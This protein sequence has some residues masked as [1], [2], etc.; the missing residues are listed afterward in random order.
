MRIGMVCEAPADHRTAT[1]LA[2]RVLGHS[3]ETTCINPTI[4]MDQAFTRW[5]N[6]DRHQHDWPRRRVHGFQ[7]NSAP[8]HGQ[9]LAARKAIMLFAGKVDALIL[10][11]DG[12]DETNARRTAME[13]ARTDPRTPSP[14]RI[15]VAVPSPERE[16]WHIVGFDPKDD[17][18]R[19]KL[20][21]ARRE[22]G[23]DPRTRSE[24]LS[25]GKDTAKRN[26]KRVLDLLT[27]R[28]PARTH[29]CITDAPLETLRS[30]GQENGLAAFLGDIERLR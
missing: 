25:H 21:A 3:V 12:D 7:G 27:D 16:A 29:A 6:L 18:E 9:T 23:F 14:D 28:D 30:R 4:D 15:V 17:D 26:A 13:R 1:T 22:L 2:G 10:M 24:E 5:K 19:R 8:L 20:A 11:Q